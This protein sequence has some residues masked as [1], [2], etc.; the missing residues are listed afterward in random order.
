MSA[1][2][3][4]HS[5]GAINKAGQRIR[6]GEAKADDW[7]ILRDFRDFRAF[8]LFELFPPVVRALDGLAAQATCR[9]KRI[10]SIVRKLK[11]QSTMNLSQMDDLVG[12][13]VLADS[14]EDQS[15]AIQ[16][17]KTHLNIPKAKDYVSQ[18]RAD[19]YRAVHLIGK[20]DGSVGEDGFTRTFPY[21]FQVRT[22]LQN[23]WANTSEAFGEQVKEGGGLQEI[24]S[25]L[26]ELSKRIHEAEVDGTAGSNCPG[27]RT[28]GHLQVVTLLYDRKSGTS[29]VDQHRDD[30][31]RALLVFSYL[32]EQFLNDARRE[33]ALLGFAADP[34]ILDTS[35]LDEL[36]ISHVRYYASTGFPALP[37]FLTEVLPERPRF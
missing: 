22:C 27:L 24:R 33:V 14:Q 6:D 18:P 28:R 36:T 20:Q 3:L 15:A 17:L 19:G 9:V 21:E 12:L 35:E 26:D 5:N 25:Y 29:T 10:R 31:E 34:N 23:L 8:G 7:S 13:R 11:R 4:T 32:E 30:F 16:S 1:V 37:Q 2:Q